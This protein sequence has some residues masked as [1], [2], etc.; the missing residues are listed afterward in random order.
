MF[1][2]GISAYLFEKIGEISQN[3]ALPTVSGTVFILF[4]CFYLLS[5]LI[6]LCENLFSDV[7]DLKTAFSYTRGIPVSKKTVVFKRAVG[8]ISF[9]RPFLLRIFGRGQ[10]AVPSTAFNKK[11]T[12]IPNVKTVTT[13]K[14]APCLRGQRRTY[15]AKNMLYRFLR[16][17]L[18]LLF[19]V[20]LIYRVAIPFFPL[21]S[22]FIGLISAF[23]AF[24]VLYLIALAF[25]SYKTAWISQNENIV[26]VNAVYGFTVKCVA[27]SK[28]DIS[29][30]KII[31][32]PTDIKENTCTVKITVYPMG[33]RVK[34][35]CITDIF[36]KSGEDCKKGAKK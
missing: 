16:W 29:E 22:Q 20:T 33:E 13:E 25:Y 36:V 26:V 12:P 6:S 8:A 1:G 31:R 34:I 30:I 21:F 18:T 15:A 11:D 7:K 23:L 9:V 28:K 10:I 19:F 3:V 35:K 5:F 2:V 14:I 4:F 24:A 32:Y 17:R 27:F